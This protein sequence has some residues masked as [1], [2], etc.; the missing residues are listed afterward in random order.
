MPPCIFVEISV[1]ILCLSPLLN[2]VIIWLSRKH[3]WRIPDVEISLDVFWKCSLSLACPFIKCW[4][5]SFNFEKDQFMIFLLFPSFLLNYGIC[6]FVC[7]DYVY[8]QMGLTSCY[9]FCLFSDCCRIYNIWLYS[10]YL[11][12]VFHFYSIVN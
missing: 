6:S 5:A 8:L 3:L 12:I 9:H 7:Y 2:Q 10:V 11:Q 4:R 1:W